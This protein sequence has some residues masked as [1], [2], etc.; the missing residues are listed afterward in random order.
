[1]TSSSLDLCSASSTSIPIFRIRCTSSCV[2]RTCSAAIARSLACWANRSTIVT[3]SAATANASCLWARFSYRACEQFL[4]AFRVSD[5]PLK[6][7]FFVPR[8]R[9]TFRGHLEHTALRGLL[10]TLVRIR[11]V[12]PLLHTLSNATNSG[13][14]ATACNAAAIRSL[15][16]AVGSSSRLSRST[17]VTSA[18]V[19]RS[20]VARKLEGRPLLAAGAAGFGNTPAQD[21][22][23]SSVHLSPAFY[24]IEIPAILRL[25]QEAT[26][27]PF[28]TPF[29]TRQMR[30]GSVSKVI[31]TTGSRPP[32]QPTYCSQ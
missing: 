31:S 28:R 22:P 7:L 17:A 23:Q 25:L 9:H 18:C 4:R 26:S 1:M 3:R 5:D 2:R 12:P 19:D 32:V 10:R 15:P 27:R 30:C 20:A 16:V 11:F 8:F 13:S 24:V 29:C 6:P 21:L 14:C